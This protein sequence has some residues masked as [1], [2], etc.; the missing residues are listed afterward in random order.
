MPKKAKAES[1]ERAILSRLRAR[2]GEHSAL[3]LIDDR[4]AAQITEYIPTGIDVLDHYVIG[5]GGLPVGRI[6]E[7][8][9]ENACGK[10]SLA[11]SCIASCQ[12]MG[13]IAVVLDAE[14]TFDEERAGVYGVDTE[15]LLIV[16]PQHME[17]GFEE[18]K[19]TLIAHDP[20]DG[21]I[22][23]VLDSVAASLPSDLS[24]LKAG[25]KQQP[26]RLAAL[27]SKELPKLLPLL[28]KSRGH[29]MMLNQTRTKF[30][31]MFGDNTTTPGGNAPKFYASVRLAFFGGKKVENEFGEHLGKVVT[32]QASK[33]RLA[34]PFRKARVQLNYAHG[35]Q[36]VYSTL[37]HAK[38]FK[39]IEPREKGFK[40]AG[41]AGVK[42]Y[43]EACKRLKWEP[44]IPSVVV[45]GEAR[46]VDDD[47]D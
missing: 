36:N 17:E 30:G 14:Y 7:V 12:R 1:R 6:S 24:E 3:S 33:N 42:A 19:E 38:R 8:Y 10:T 13:G 5:R 23:I 40:G 9:G 2:F 39:V 46:E 25:D 29:L 26:G 15:S 4:A 41:K 44:R 45:E 27:T 21:P 31:V 22:L 18:I 11:Y 47:A 28:N 43:V 34:P 32:I 20:D 35:W 37:E 16:Q